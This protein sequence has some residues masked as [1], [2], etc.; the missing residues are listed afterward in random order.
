MKTS[1]SHLKLRKE[2]NK[3]KAE[4]NLDILKLK[5]CTWENYFYANQ[6]QL[7]KTKQHKKN[8][9]KIFLEKVMFY[10]FH[11]YSQ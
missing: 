4:S 9:L 6:K 8:I 1:T 3:A 2:K 5:K 7:Y 11:L 10:V